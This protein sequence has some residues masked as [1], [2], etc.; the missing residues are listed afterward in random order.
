[1]NNPDR[2]IKHVSDHYKVFQSFKAWVK[3]YMVVVTCRASRRQKAGLE[4]ENL[5]I[6][7]RHIGAVLTGPNAHPSAKLL[8]VTIELFC[9]I[10]SVAVDLRWT[11][12]NQQRRSLTE[13]IKSTG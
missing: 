12:R 9:I 7:A 1:M 10:L 5:G 11:G 13:K 4:G 2:Q 3:L 6:R 8:K